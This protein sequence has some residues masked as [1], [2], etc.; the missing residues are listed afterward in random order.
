LSMQRLQQSHD[1]PS[2]I[3]ANS[4]SSGTGGRMP[5]H[6]EDDHGLLDAEGRLMQDLP[7]HRARLEREL[8]ERARGGDRAAFGELVRLHRAQAL[9]WATSI[10][11]D[12]YMAEDIVQEA[13]IRA[14]LHLGTLVDTDRFLPWLQRIIRNQAYMKLRRGG[15]FGK[16]TPFAGIVRSHGGGPTADPSADSEADTDWTD[17]DRILFRMSGSIASGERRDTDPAGRLLRKELLDS[18]HALLH[19]LTKR[20]RQIFEAHFFGELPPEEI[21]ALFGTTR[22]NVYNLLSRSRAKVQKERIRVAI[23]GYVRKRAELGKPLVN[24]LTP[25]TL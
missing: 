25:P 21:A 22:A 17:L 9:G 6:S 2:P 13:L 3:D 10:A 8:V 15:P 1:A 19:G 23:S 11:R 5:S 20:E 12:T 4:C 16:E 18:L 7:A 24:I 14:F